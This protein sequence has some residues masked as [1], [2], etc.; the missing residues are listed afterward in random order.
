MNDEDEEVKIVYIDGNI[1]TGQLRSVRGRIL[2]DTETTITIIRH[3]GQ[4]TIGKN[5]LIKIEQWK[6]GESYNGTK[7]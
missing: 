5:F 2:K 7:S 4:L 6:S 1:N 3:D